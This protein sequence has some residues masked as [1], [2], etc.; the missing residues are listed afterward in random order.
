[1]LGIDTGKSCNSLGYD[2]PLQLHARVKADPKV[3][4]LG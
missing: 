2:R 1:M 4:C 3:P